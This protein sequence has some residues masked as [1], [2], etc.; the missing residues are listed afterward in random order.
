[1]AYQWQYV[2]G[3]TS[4]TNML[5]FNWLKCLLTFDCHILES[6]ICLNKN[7]YFG[8]NLRSKRG[9]RYGFRP[10]LKRGHRPDPRWASY[11]LNWM[12]MVFF[13]FFYWEW[14]W[15]LFQ[16]KLRES[17]TWWKCSFFSPFQYKV[18]G[19]DKIVIFSHSYQNNM[20]WYDDAIGST[21]RLRINLF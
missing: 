16:C 21:I 20:E 6:K 13:F 11:I 15:F 9:L 2:I 5:T 17:I 4:R 18:G 3:Q 14:R 1:M 12:K 8:H 10:R 7:T 19:D